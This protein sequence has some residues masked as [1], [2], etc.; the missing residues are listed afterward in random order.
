[1]TMMYLGWM[2]T[3]LKI[4]L[5]RSVW[6]VFL[7]S[8]VHATSKPLCLV[9]TWFSSAGYSGV[10]SIRWSVYEIVSEMLW[11]LTSLN[12]LAFSSCLVFIFLNLKLFMLQFFFSLRVLI[13][14][15]NLIFSSVVYDGGFSSTYTTCTN[16]LIFSECVQVSWTTGASTSL[17]QVDATEKI[18]YLYTICQIMC[19]A[20]PFGVWPLS[21]YKHSTCRR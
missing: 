12:I 6:W 11:F 17:I 2:Q 5:A 1:M 7:L 14:I 10:S 20:P 8:I 9:L 21:S 13:I 18:F 19:F 3:R 16:I 15:S 4:K